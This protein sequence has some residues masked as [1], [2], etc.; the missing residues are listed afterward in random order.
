MTEDSRSGDTFVDMTDACLEIE[1][2]MRESYSV[3]EDFMASTS[4]IKDE[5][6]ICANA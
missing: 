5:H 6:K 4:H 3:I 2:L 1:R